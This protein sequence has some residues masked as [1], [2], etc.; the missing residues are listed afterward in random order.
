MLLFHKQIMHVIADNSAALCLPDYDDDDSFLAEWVYG[1]CC[2]CVVCVY[3]QI[4][5]RD[6]RHIT[7]YRTSLLYI[8]FE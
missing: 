3:V 1:D 5:M 2:V 7:L 6:M 8:S 4:D